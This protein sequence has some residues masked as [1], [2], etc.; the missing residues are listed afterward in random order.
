[1]ASSSLVVS[2]VFSTL[3]TQAVLGAELRALEAAASTVPARLELAESEVV[4]LKRALAEQAAHLSR[5]NS[6]RRSLV[7][8][9]RQ[10]LF[11]AAAGRCLGLWR[12]QMDALQLRALTAW[13]APQ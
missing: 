7:T 2:E 11:H 6:L 3:I 9:K 5:E 10:S 13:R 1:M 4:E 8:Q 12:S